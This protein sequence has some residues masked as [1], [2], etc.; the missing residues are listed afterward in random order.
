VSE[1]S[2]GAAIYAHLP[3]VLSTGNRI[4]PLTLPQ[5]VTLP[6][7]VWQLVGDNPLLTHDNAQ[8]HPL[9]SGARYEQSRLQFST[10]ANSYDAAEAASL[11]LRTAITGYRGTWGDVE[12]ESVEP[13]LSLDDY[14]PETGLFRRISDYTISWHGGPNGGS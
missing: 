10:W 14:E 3:A 7:H 4:Y 6:A 8:A 2:L 11:E 1:L 9:Y 5:R 12:I 13:V